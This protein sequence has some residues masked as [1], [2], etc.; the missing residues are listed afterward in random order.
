MRA[1]DVALTC[2]VL[3]DIASR[4]PWELS[5][6]A[7]HNVAAF[8]T[9]DVLVSSH[10]RGGG[11]GGGGGG[12]EELYWRL[13]S[14]ENGSRMRVLMKRDFHAHATP[15]AALAESGDDSEEDASAA[16]AV[17]AASVVAAAAVMALAGDGETPR[18]CGEPSRAS[19]A[20]GEG[21]DAAGVVV[22]GGGGGGGGAGDGGESV[23]AAAAAASPT[24][25][26][27]PGTPGTD[28]G[29]DGDGGDGDE[30]RDGGATSGRES[31]EEDAGAWE[32]LDLPRA[33]RVG[34]PALYATTAQLVRAR[35]VCVCVCGGGGG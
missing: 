23:A 1:Q 3:R 33:P 16:A 20:T 4:P 24:P 6:L 22:A 13:D 10:A 29:G 35:G 28:R 12:G 31:E 15:A 30:F 25:P 26:V 34:T 5:A 9:D 27:P 2:S 21:L 18:A 32:V 17:A 11:G 14:R 8:A 19:D 7:R